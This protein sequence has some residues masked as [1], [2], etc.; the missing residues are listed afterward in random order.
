MDHAVVLLE[1]KDRVA[2]ITVNRPHALNALNTEVFIRLNEALDTISERE[3]IRVVVLKGAGGNAF[4]AGADIREMLGMDVLGA[5]RFAGGG[6]RALQK[7]ASLDD[8]IFIA[9]INGYALGGGLELAMGCDIRIATPKSRLGLPECTLGVIPGIGGTQRLPRLVG[10]AAAIEMLATG[11]Q[12]D[13]SRAERIGL[14]N[15]VVEEDNL[16]SYCE[17]LAEKICRN[18]PAAVA[19]CKTLVNC[20]LEMELAKGVAMET[21][22]FAKCFATPDQKEGMGAFVEKRKPIYGPKPKY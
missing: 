20:G 15:A 1:L 2:Y 18:S 22:T 6:N 12:V 16:D 3:N 4:I 7:M 11:S 8:K 14:V 9:V 17:A 21:L 10:K 5:E 13:A 19:A